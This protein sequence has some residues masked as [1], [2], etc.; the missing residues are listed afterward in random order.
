MDEETEEFFG[1][2]LVIRLAGRAAEDKLLGSV[3]PGA[4]GSPDSELGQATELAVA[5]ET[6]LGFAGTWPLPSRIGPRCSLLS[7]RVSTRREDAYGRALNSSAAITMQSSSSRMLM[8]DN[9]LEGLDLLAVL[10]EVRKR[11]VPNTCDKAKNDC[12]TSD[13]PL[14]AVESENFRAF[15]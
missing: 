14:H 1:G 5:M 12:G 13:I 10:K 6:A 8:E 9:T 11:M 15:R 7:E 4:G 2:L 3:T